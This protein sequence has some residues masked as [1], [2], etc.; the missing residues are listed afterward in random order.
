[1]MIMTRKHGV[2]HSL[3]KHVSLPTFTNPW[4]G[5]TAV[6]YFQ[7]R[8]KAKEAMTGL[9][10]SDAVRQRRTMLSIGRRREKVVEGSRRWEK[11][12]GA[13]EGGRW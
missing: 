6:K 3:R 1:M 5:R 12:A 2:R 4:P 9:A 11:A 10:A 13:A 8:W 7:R